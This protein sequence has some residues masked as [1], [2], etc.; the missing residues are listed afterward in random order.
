MLSMSTLERPVLE[1]ILKSNIKNKPMEGV[2]C[3]IKSQ[4]GQKGDNRERPKIESLQLKAF[5]EAGMGYFKSLQTLPTTQLS[6]S[7]TTGKGAINPPKGL[8]EIPKWETGF[9]DGKGIKDRFYSISF[10]VLRNI[11]KRVAPIA[12]IQNVRMMQINSYCQI[13]YNEDDV[14]FMVKLKDKDATP[15]RKQKDTMKQVEDFFLKSGVVVE[16]GYSK[17]REGFLA[18]VKKVVGDVMTIDQV[19]LSLRYNVGGDLLDYWVLD[20]ATIKKV[21]KD[22]GYAGNKRIK[23]VQEINRK[24]V[25]TFTE[26]ELIFNFTNPRSDHRK[27]DYGYSYI[28]MCLDMITS[29]LFAMRWNKE[30][31]NS[32]SQPKG[33]FTFEG[34][35]FDQGDLEELQRQWVAMFRGIEGM[36][37]TPFLQHGAKWNNISQTSRDM[38]YYK[39]IQVLESWICAVHGMDPAELGKK[40]NESQSIVVGANTT[41]KQIAFSADRG[42][43]N[44]LTFVSELFNKVKDKRK[45]WDE[46]YLLFT[47]LEKK[48]QKAELELDEKQ[49]KTYM[50]L[51]EKRKEKDLKPDP[52][53]DIILD[54]QYIQ[55]RSQK[56]AA[57]QAQQ[58]EAENEETEF[59]GE[60]SSEV[61]EK[62]TMPVKKGFTEKLSTDEMIKSA[63]NLKKSNVSDYI[64]IVIE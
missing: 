12:A 25:E 56:E 41:N 5:Q 17:E 4:P 14:G 47:G 39:Y 50:T 35:N 64:E 60:E 33:F 22:T 45:E 31:F 38:E 61:F 29:W 40:W 16:D 34:S 30:A 7:L 2:L 21:R 62:E 3:E 37:K 42:L 49:V 26:D 48:D 8:F 58:M 9:N 32:A 13:S 1:K 51:N 44:L 20:G 19:A 36:W 24:V 43:K 55:Y 28:E 57:E 27:S 59:E 11:A 6:K 54:P 18:V 15:T 53:G 63:E 10:N 52:F 23:F 46:F